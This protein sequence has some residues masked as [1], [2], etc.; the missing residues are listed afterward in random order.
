MA[1]IEVLKAL[2]RFGVQEKPRAFDLVREWLILGKDYP[3][4][5]G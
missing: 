4:A 5:G 1:S 3:L 2:T